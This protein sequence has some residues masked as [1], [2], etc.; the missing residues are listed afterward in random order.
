LSDGSIFEY[1]YDAEDRRVSKKINGV[2]KEK[3][4]YDGEDIALVV[5]A[6]GTIVE[7]YLYGDGTDNV[8]SRVSAGTTVWSLGDRQGSVVDLVDESG[9]VLNHFVYDSFGN[10]T[11]TTGVDFRFGYT[12]RELDTETGL[13]YYRARYYDSSLGRF[14]SEDPVGFSAGDTNLYRYVNNSP[15]NFT[16]PTGMTLSGWADD[17]LNAFDSFNAGLWNTATFGLTNK[18]RE[19]L[20]NGAGKIA[21]LN[22]EGGFYEAGSLTGAVATFALG[23]GVEAQAVRLS[24][25]LVYGVRAYNV[26]GTSVGA[27]QAVQH[28]AEGTATGWDLL[29]FAPLAGHAVGFA[30]KNARKIGGAIKNTFDDV[31][32]ILNPHRLEMV[33]ES[34]G[35]GV[36]HTNN[37]H[38]S[39]LSPSHMAIEGSG[40]SEAV[41]GEVISIYR[42]MSFEEAKTTLKTQKLQPKI[43]GTS[44]DKDKYLSES[45]ENVFSFAGKNNAQ[46]AIIEFVLDRSKYDKLMSTAV[47]Q[48]GSKKSPEIKYHYE[49]MKDK[50]LRNIGVTPDKLEKF[51][52]TVKNIR[53]LSDDEIETIRDLIDKQWY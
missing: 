9:N 31:R 38:P 27:V 4:V 45:L 12:G 29:N 5:N 6:A 43:E 13:Y 49:N 46:E 3:Y 32:S 15:T 14:I 53:Q 41:S 37:S 35:G 21:K 8:L 34:V 42:K 24:A 10:R 17:A 26:V 18:I 40:S 50:S 51:N 20:P 7:R 16:D 39:G 36:P 11:A 19:V 25:A 28:V 48:K 44:Q 52:D 33:T 1:G 23:Y 47:K 30:A 2:T 22:Q